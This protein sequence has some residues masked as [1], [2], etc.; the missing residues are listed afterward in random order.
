MNCVYMSTPVW[1]VSCIICFKQ[2]KLC[3][4]AFSVAILSSMPT[5]S[6]ESHVTSII[7]GELSVL[8]GLPNYHSN[9]LPNYHS[10]KPNQP[11]QLE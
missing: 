7:S 10:N 11:S 6:Y 4:G 5:Y 9:G 8:G 1:L 2:G 3:I